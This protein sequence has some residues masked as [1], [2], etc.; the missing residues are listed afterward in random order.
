VVPIGLIHRSDPPTVGILDYLI[1]DR[2]IGHEIGADAVVRCGWARTFFAYADLLISLSALAPRSSASG[3]NEGVMAFASSLAHRAV[4]A[5]TA[6]APAAPAPI[7]TWAPKRS[8]AVLSMVH[9][10]SG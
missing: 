6:A 3:S 1:A 8:T 5:E 10:R 2:E 4:G 9:D 7:A